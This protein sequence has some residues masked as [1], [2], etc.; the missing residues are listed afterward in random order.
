MQTKKNTGSI[1]R[2][3]LA[4]GICAR[5]RN[6]QQVRVCREDKN[7]SSTR[8][9]HYLGRKYQNIDKATDENGIVRLFLIF[10]R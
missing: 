7:Q 6:G 10:C 4:M 5:T 3:V 9:L 8:M 1:K 2:R